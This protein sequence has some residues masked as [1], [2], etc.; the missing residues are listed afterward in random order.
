MFFKIKRILTAFVGYKLESLIAP[1]AEAINLSDV[2]AL[3]GYIYIV[4]NG[5][6]N[7]SASVQFLI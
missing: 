6:R 2:I 1:Y 3:S 5:A 4:V 7:E